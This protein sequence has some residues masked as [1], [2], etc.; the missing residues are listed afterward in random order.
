MQKLRTLSL[1]IFFTSIFSDKTYF[2]RGRIEK[3][4]NQMKKNVTEYA[5]SLT[6]YLTALSLFC[7]VNQTLLKT[8]TVMCIRATCAFFCALI[9][10]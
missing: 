6:Y 8:N 10:A 3:I 2:L 4:N 5:K 7:M 9:M 1:G